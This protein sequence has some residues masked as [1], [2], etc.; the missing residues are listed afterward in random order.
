M[1]VFKKYLRNFIQNYRDTIK[2]SD[3][4]NFEDIRE[5]IPEASIT[6]DVIPIVCGLYGFSEYSD[7]TGIK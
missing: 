4:C 2:I 3:D 6:A 1:K 5:L 7:H